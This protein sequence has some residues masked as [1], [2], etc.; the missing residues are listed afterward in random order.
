M[1]NY[2]IYDQ[3]KK[4][5][6]ADKSF[7]MP[8]HKAR[9]DFKSKFAVAPL[10]VT[11]LSY[12][13]NLLCP[14]GVIARAQTDIAEILGAR[15][16]YIMTDGSSS[17]VLSMIFAV[18]KP[19]SKI[20]V[21]R[22]S[23]QSVWNACKLLNIEPVIV[24][25]ESRDG[26]LLPPD[27]E[28]VEKLVSNDRTIAAMIVTSPDYYGN[29]APLSE[30][31]AVLK[32]YGRYFLVDGAHGAHLAFE[33][34]RQGYAGASADIWV[35]GAHKTMP[36][37]TQGAIVSVNCEKLVPA[38]EEGLSVFRTTSPSFPITASVEYAVKYL[39]NNPE[40]IKEAKAAVAAFR[41]KCPYKLYP[42]DDWTKLAI[43]FEPLGV[44]SHDV[45]EILEKKGIYAELSDGKYILFYLSPMTTASD[46]NALSVAL[47]SA[48]MNKKLK[49]EFVKRPEL[50]VPG[51][52]YSFLYAL[53]QPREKIPLSSAVGRM[54]ARNAGIAPPCT[55]VTVA[56]EIISEA[57]V[58]ILGG[59]DGV[60]GVEDGKIWVVKK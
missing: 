51:R 25:G 27:P 46:L 58:K 52:T 15:R 44:S 39:Y 49:K 18:S 41:A 12:S 48:L 30:Y 23:H 55:P 57:A 10:D 56:G 19:G 5:A 1:Y 59:S 28:L 47:S 34:S 4:Y 20:I 43:D 35:D 54:A 2:L 17:G 13:D 50:P 22:N 11:E 32:K 40:L 9:G 53:K 3:L 14:K 36:A 31:A 42:S 24:Q 7:H 60:F 45:A 21:P 16:S 29:I 37:L 8:G 26:V 33:K 6:K 38:L